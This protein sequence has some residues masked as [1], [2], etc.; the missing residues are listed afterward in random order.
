MII[1]KF[2]EKYDQNNWDEFC[3]TAAYCYNKSSPSNNNFSP[4]YLIFAREP[5]SVVD[6][7]KIKLE[8]KKNL[9]QH[10]QIIK[11]DLEKAWKKAK[12]Q[13]V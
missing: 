6:F 7:G 3:W 10:V 2:V 5:Y 1:T 13:T 4:D 9:E 12:E 11:D 8:G